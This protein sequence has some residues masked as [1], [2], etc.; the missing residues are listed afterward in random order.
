MS[1]KKPS[2]KVGT[3]PTGL[4]AGRAPAGVGLQGRGATYGTN[5]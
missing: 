2:G 4:R 1:R 5:G 3:K